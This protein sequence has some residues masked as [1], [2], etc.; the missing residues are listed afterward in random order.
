LLHCGK[1]NG[2]TDLALA[3]IIGAILA[4][5]TA[6]L[7]GFFILITAFLGLTVSK[8]IYCVRGRGVSFLRS[9]H[10]FSLGLAAFVFHIFEKTAM[11]WLRGCDGS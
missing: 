8:K 3:T 9:R 4:R 6:L 7:G 11:V 2:I 10:G 5:T 1:N